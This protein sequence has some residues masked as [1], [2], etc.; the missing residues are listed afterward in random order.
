ML[1]GMDESPEASATTQFSVRRPF[2]SAIQLYA[3]G[4]RLKRKGFL[5][6]TYLLPMA[7][8]TTKEVQVRGVFGGAS[9]TVD[10]FSHQV[11]PK[12]PTWAFVLAALPLA[13]ALFG[14]AAG[15]A[16][17]AA[18]MVFNLRIAN[19]R[20]NPALKA[21]GMLALTAVV[22]VP[23]M[24]I[25][26]GGLPSSGTGVDDLA[27]GTCINGIQANSRFDPSALQIVSCDGLHDA[28]KF[29]EFEH[30]E[31]ATY[32]GVAGFEAFAVDVCFPAFEG[33]VG[34]STNDSVVGILPYLPDERSWAQGDHLLVCFAAKADGSQLTGSVK[35]TKK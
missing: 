1:F 21:A 14:G 12:L 2:W 25:R 29:G 5:G 13:L 16:L 34:I 28:E 31:S 35:N 9:V 33:Y 17:G 26:L 11:E 18:A 23:F 4:V 6:S 32:P 7:D 24:L 10:G 15:G 20:W 8:G 3:D 22:V 19:L 30:P 27:I